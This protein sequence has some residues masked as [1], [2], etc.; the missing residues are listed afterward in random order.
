M[1]NNPITNDIPKTD[2]E[3][4]A[5]LYGFIKAMNHWER[6]SYPESRQLFR[7]GEHIVDQQ[8][9]MAYAQRKNQRLKEIFSAYCTLRERPY[10]RQST[11]QH[12]PEYDPEN[13]KLLDI[14]KE[15]SQ[16]V[17]IFT[18]ET[19]GFCHKNRYVL[20]RKGGE[21]RVDNKKWLDPEGKWCKGIL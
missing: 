21:W 20:L 17:V 16:R 5:V 2:L 19:T 6:E 7:E 11:F 13:E 9:L 12:P 8:L 3:P 4:V 10:G 1:D 14:V 18:Q 15:S